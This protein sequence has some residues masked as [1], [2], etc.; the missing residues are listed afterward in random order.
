[1]P[2]KSISA[3]ARKAFLAKNGVCS[4]C[5][6]MINPVKEGWQIEH[7]TPLALGGADDAT[8]WT[9]VHAKCHLSKSRQDVKDIALAKRRETKNLGASPPP[10]R[11]IQSQGFPKSGTKPDKL[12]LPPRRSIY[13]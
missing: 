12:P 10:R 5:G 8:N 6:G 2:R 3:K 1:M 4:L 7:T 9:A 11:P 13:Q